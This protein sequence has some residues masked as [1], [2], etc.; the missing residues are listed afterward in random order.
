MG[1]L[2]GYHWF[3]RSLLINEPFGKQDVDGIHLVP[4]MLPKITQF[5]YL[6]VLTLSKTVSDE[7]NMSFPWIQELLLG[8]VMFVCKPFLAYNRNFCD[9]LAGSHHIRCSRV[10]SYDLN[11]CID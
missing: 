3:A 4:E 2:R 9:D 5:L 1:L 11:K 7:C 10:T 6:S 8:V